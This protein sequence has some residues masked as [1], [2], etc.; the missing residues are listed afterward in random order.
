ML[1][2][3]WMIL[4]GQQMYHGLVH[5]KQVSMHLSN[6]NV[7]FTEVEAATHP[8]AI[9]N[10]ECQCQLL[11]HSVEEKLPILTCNMMPNKTLLNFS[12]SFSGHQICWTVAPQL[13][14]RAKEEPKYCMP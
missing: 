3:D 7:A 12:S 9:G 4:A 13:H 11:C 1:L 10:I 6:D 8:R 5:M 2:Q 14:Q